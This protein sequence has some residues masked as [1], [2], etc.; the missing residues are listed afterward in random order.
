[1]IGLKGNSLIDLDWGTKSYSVTVDGHEI[2]HDGST[3]C[4]LDDSRVAFYSLRGKKLSFPLPEG[5]NEKQ[6]A[7]FV[8][9]VHKPEPIEVAVKGGGIA[10]TVPLRQ[11]VIAFRDGITAK[12]RLFRPA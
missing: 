10:V 2:A 1:M 3:S 8:L 11:P 4:P 7:A 12:E 6:M 5:W 9:D